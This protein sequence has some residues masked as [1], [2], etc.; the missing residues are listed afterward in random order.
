MY[1]AQVIS[2]S[3][4]IGLEGLVN[5]G[6]RDRPEHPPDQPGLEIRLSQGLIRIGHMGLS[7]SRLKVTLEPIDHNLYVPRFSTE[8]EFS[9]DLILSLLDKTGFAWL[10]DGIARHENPE[11]VAN[12]LGKQLFSY[13]S[14]SDFVGKRLL[15][16][17]CGS[18]ASTMAMAS[19]L[20]QT[21]IVGVELEASRLVLAN[22][23]KAFRGLENVNF[24]CSP[25]GSELPSG[26]GVF[27][28][29]MLSA[30]YEHLLPSERKTVM[31]LLWSVARPG[32]KIF[33]NLTPY[34]YWPVEAHSTGLWFI[35]YLPDKLAHLVVQHFAG[36]N[37][38]INKSKDWN[39]HLRGGL[40]GATEGEIL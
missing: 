38:H 25:S 5:V 24:Y 13:V 15:D 35:N 39:V 17:G 4:T 36:R 28:F 32:A 20:P 12:V 23:I 30:V 33:L 34:R 6:R 40:R 1:D 11:V 29:I 10:C 3:W 14:P 31:P 7:D 19:L 21:E 8:T 9:L 37:T 22:Q 26:I 18:G 2:P 27:D 16:F